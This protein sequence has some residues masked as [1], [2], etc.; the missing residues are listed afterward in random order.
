MRAYSNDGNLR[1]IIIPTFPIV[2]SLEIDN[3]GTVLYIGGRDEQSKGRLDVFDL[4]RAQLST[5]SSAVRIAG[6]ILMAI[7]LYLF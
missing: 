2:T 1:G 5:F 7:V 4:E 6:P 3:D